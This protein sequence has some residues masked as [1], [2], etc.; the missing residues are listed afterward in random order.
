[1]LWE[2]N[3][4]LLFRT[5]LHNKK[6]SSVEYKS[7]S[8]RN[9]TKTEVIAS[10]TIYDTCSQIL[11]K[12]CLYWQI[13]T[14]VRH[15][16]ILIW[17]ILFP[18]MLKLDHT[19]PLVEKRIISTVILFVCREDCHDSLACIT[20][21]CLTFLVGINYVL[22]LYKSMKQKL[23]GNLER[24]IKFSEWENKCNVKYI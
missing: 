3:L 7:A 17:S 19:H 15:Y 18:R 4:C 12:Q 14:V 2:I 10:V 11:Y 24:G 13:T 21:W 5:F 1:M 9:R 16:L 8:T 20:V 6:L 23:Y 22:P